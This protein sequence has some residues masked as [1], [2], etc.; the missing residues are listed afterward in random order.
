M[1]QSAPPRCGRSALALLLAFPTLFPGLEAQYLDPPPPSAW[2]IEGATIVQVDGSEQ[3]GVTLVVRGGL[4]ETLRAGAPIPA[5]ARVI[6]GNG[7]VLRVYPG[8]ID[9]HGSAST[10]FPVPNRDG[11]SSW[12]PTREVQNFTPHRRA[13]DYLTATGESVEGDRRRGVVASVVFPGRG[14][15]PGQLS[16]ILHSPDART[17]RELVLNPSLGQVMSFQGAQGAY[18]GTLMAVQAMLRQAFAD[19]EHYEA[20]RAAYTSDP[21]G[22]G[23]VAVDEDLERLGEVTAGEVPVYF[24]ADGAEEIRRVLS[25]ADEL[26]FRPLVVGGQRAGVLAEELARRR[27]PVFLSADFPEPDEWDPEQESEDA[28]SPAAHREK[29]DLEEIFRTAGLLEAAGVEFAFTSGGEAGLDLLENV[30]RAIEYGLTE[31][32]ALR[33]LSADPAALLGVPQLARIEEGMSATFVVADGPLFE[34]GTAIAWTFVNGVAEK[35]SEPRAPG[36]EGGDGEVPADW[37]GRWSGSVSVE[38]QEIPVSITLVSGAAGWSGT[39]TSPTGPDQ[40]IQNISID[41]SDI[42]FSIPVPDMGGSASFNGTRSGDAI[43][44]QGS[45]SGPAGGMAFTFTFRRVEGGAR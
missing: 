6:G 25:L 45:L 30:R 8:F 41:G 42:S 12:N 10:S 21:R 33:A 26:G 17:A 37:A 15:L 3:E 7:S 22:L 16:L 32:G 18:P 1:R 31:T 27:V 19:A 34:E 13:S 29:V 5:D 2:A 40:P 9:G 20:T 36:A 28:L 14:P 43:S 44:G 23:M 35:G 38:G 4:I 24:L 39:A 11:I